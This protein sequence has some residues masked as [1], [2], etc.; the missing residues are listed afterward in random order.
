MRQLATA[1]AVLSLVAIPS[2]ASADWI[3]DGY[4]LKRTLPT[5][6]R[7]SLL[8]EILLEETDPLDFFDPN[9]SG[10]GNRTSDVELWRP[11]VEEHFEPGDVNRAL[12]IISCESG[13]NPYAKNRT[14]TASGLFQHLRAWWSGDWGVTE[15]FD[16]FNPEDSIR[17]GAALAYGTSSSWRNWY[18]S[19]FCWN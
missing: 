14:S 16:P 15:P 2:K 8:A 5:E 4:E 12:R 10:M 18:P 7:Q 3:T 6:V 11:F 13:G 19:A 1:A 17:A 9:F